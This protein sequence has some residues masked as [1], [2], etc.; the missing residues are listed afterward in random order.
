MRQTRR[1][2]QR[3][4]QHLERR[5]FHAFCLPIRC[6][7]EDAK[8]VISGK[9]VIGQ[10]CDENYNTKA[11]DK[12]LAELLGHLADGTPVRLVNKQFNRDLHAL[13]STMTGV[14][15][16]GKV[17]RSWDKCEVFGLIT[18]QYN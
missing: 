15:M 10:K 13:K 3:G 12:G 1:C 8:L 16:I 7:V 17:P 6:R 18:E 2:V 4:V 11:V 14:S 5:K 9:Y